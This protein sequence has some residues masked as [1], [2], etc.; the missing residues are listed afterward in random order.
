[1]VALFGLSSKASSSPAKSSHD[2]DSLSLPP[3]YPTNTP[4]S[5]V[6]ATATTTTATHVVTTTTQ[7]T[8]HFFSLP[9]WRRR[10]GTSAYSPSSTRSTDELGVITAR[11]DPN[12]S[13]STIHARNKDL[14]PTP[15][16]SPDN[17]T[18]HT[19]LSP[20]VSPLQEGDGKAA[21]AEAAVRSGSGPSSRASS[22]QR[23]S[24]SSYA[25][26]DSIHA[27]QPTVI[28]ARAAL[29][30]GLPHAAPASV[31]A[32]SSSSEV[33]TVAFLPQRSPSTTDLRRPNLFVRHAK[34]FYKEPDSRN[35]A[36][37]PS[38]IGERRR[39]RGL[40]LGPLHLMTSGAK[41]KQR[42]ASVP[43]VAEPTEVKPLTRK[44]SFWSRKRT[45]S[46]P[47]PPAPTSPTP[48]P[49]L[50][51][52]PPV[53]P[54]TINTPVP[55]SGLSVSNQPLDL[56]RRHSERTRKSSRRQDDETHCVEPPPRPSNS[57]THA[58][59][60]RPQRPQTADDGV[61]GSPRLSFFS[62]ARPFVSSPTSSPLATPLERPVPTFPSAPP[63]PRTRAQTNPPLLHRLSVNLF[64]S[65]TSNTH[66]PTPVSSPN[67]HDATVVTSPPSSLGSSRPSLSK[68][69]VE[70]PRPNSEEETPEDYL[71]RVVEAI[72]KGEV[73][74]VLAS[75]Y[76]QSLVLTLRRLALI[77][78][79]VPMLSTPVRSTPT[80]S[81]STSLE[82][83]SI[84]RYESCSWMLASLARHNKLTVSLRHSL[85]DMFNVILTYSHPM[86]SQVMH[87][88]QARMANAM[89]I[90]RSSI[91]PSI[92]PYN[93]AHGRLQ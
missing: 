92:Q 17:L 75:R 66:T 61:F 3:P 90:N 35:D 19:R 8:T 40:S 47:E 48:R 55:S 77:T 24:R 1:M 33:N 67:T 81:A 76:V 78:P 65:S 20:D 54:F 31:S 4:D 41:G 30:L 51:T 10:G 83:R 34:S 23:A 93:V 79:L 57:S 63:E 49:T 5:A 36:P 60:R 53:S 26:S 80:L 62:E 88:Q 28:L 12:L 16:P 84:L 69:S 25:P 70:I 45:S 91:Y 37:P 46:R 64:G 7:T 29:G 39:T 73:A 9:L 44:S 2:S 72:S 82:I 21:S 74:T 13:P 59:R 56:C 14:P 22:L 87:A 52:F 43:V 71:Q 42:E 32:S 27:A 18:P 6:Y 11:L 58:R 15:E 89:I 86:V 50:P 85:H 68:P 38:A